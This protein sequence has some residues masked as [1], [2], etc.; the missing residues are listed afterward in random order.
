[1]FC[2]VGGT[3]T[4]LDLIR[5][6]LSSPIDNINEYFDS[7]FLKAPLAR[8]ST[9]LSSPPSQKAMSFGAMMMVLRHHPG[10]ARNKGGSCALIDT[11]V[12]LV[13]SAGGVI[14]TDQKVEKVLVDNGQA[15]GVRVAGGK[16]Y[17]A[18]KSVTYSIVLMRNVDFYN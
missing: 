18:N 9:K 6:F 13:K 4:T 5:T 12:K 8:L 14:L 2:L 7:E 3:N 1:M 11:L 10:M 16:E 15:V 17:R